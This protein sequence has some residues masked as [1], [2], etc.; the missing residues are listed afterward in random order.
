MR[1][2]G[3]LQSGKVVIRL[4]G[5]AARPADAT[6]KDAGGKSWPCGAA[7]KAALTRLIRARAVT[8]VLP[9]G[10]EHNIV[11][12]SCAVAGTDR[13]TWAG[14]AGLG[15]AERAERSCVGRCGQGHQVGKTR[16]LAQRRVKISGL[17]GARRYGWSPPASPEKLSVVGLRRAG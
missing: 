9:K 1:D 14:A 4:A 8:C 2:G 3:T 17:K 7:A 5:I 12:T 10:G 6:C 15:H 11:D 13:S 16:L